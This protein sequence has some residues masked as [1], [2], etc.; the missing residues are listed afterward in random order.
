MR[1]MLIFEQVP[2]TTTF[3]TFD[4]PSAELLRLL[5]ACNGKMINSD[6]STPEMQIL[7]D[8]LASKKEH[9]GNPKHPLAC[10]ITDGVELPPNSAFDRVFLFG[11]MC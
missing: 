7:S 6:D 9:C 3:Y 2:E 5:K 10:T 8:A 11:F 4:N 1:V